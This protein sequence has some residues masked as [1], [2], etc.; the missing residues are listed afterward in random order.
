[1]IIEIDTIIAALK[2]IIE[3]VTALV[4]SVLAA[5]GVTNDDNQ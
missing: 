1:M 3:T 4:K 2:S 5:F